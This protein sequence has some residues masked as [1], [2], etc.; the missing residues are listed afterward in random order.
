MEVVETP[1]V[2]K[3]TQDSIP[4]F[5]L[6]L[7]GDDDHRTT[8]FFK[9]RSRR[10][11]RDTW[12]ISIFVIVH[13]IAFI[14]T[15]IVNDCP[16]YS[17][18]HCSVKSLARLS[19]QPLSENPLLGPS[20]ST[21]DK[22]GALRRTLLV[23]HHQTWRLLR[24]P[25]LHAGFI[26]LIINLTGILLFGIYL[27]Q[28]F[29]P[30]RIGIIY[31][32]SAFFGTLVSALVIR[33]SPTV[34]ASGAFSGLLGATLSSLLRNWNLYNNQTAALLTLLFVAVFDFM[35]GLLPYIDNYANIGGFISGLLLGFSLLF[36]PELKQVTKNKTGIHDYGERISSK[37]KQNLD[38]PVLRTVSFLLFTLLLVGFLVPVLQGANV[39]QYCNWCG[40]IDCIPSKRWSC[41]DVTSSCEI[42]MNSA[43]LTLT[44]AI[45]GKFK[46]FPFTN[47]SEARTRDLCTL[48]CP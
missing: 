48:I 42:I 30:L 3:P 23:D 6:D 2:I 12:I 29:G 38:R 20:A 35:L 37:L 31:V 16:F 25:W 5:S 9:S 14:A 27:E 41:N 47:I 18:G 39:G 1:V 46:N 8:P 7:I 22:M 40:Y 4:S 45:N 34:A 17:H 26:Q 24:A 32:V 28:E 13:L 33:D 15:M 44:C 36:T 43:E 11:R 19:F 10:R 21:L